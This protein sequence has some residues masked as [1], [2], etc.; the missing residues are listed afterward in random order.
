MSK[1]THE[2]FAPNVEGLPIV[3][4]L[5]ELK[6]KSCDINW[7]DAIE[8]LLCTD[9]EGRLITDGKNLPFSVGDL[10]VIN[11]NSIHGVARGKNTRYHCLIIDYEFCKQNGVDISRLQF[12]D[13]VRSETLNN[14]YLKLVDT[15]K[16]LGSASS[17]YTVLYART[18]LLE[19]L[20]ELCREHLVKQSAVEVAE[21]PRNARVKRVLGYLSSNYSRDLTLDRI[22][23][24]VLISKFHLSRE[25]KE[26]TGQ[27]IFGYLNTLRVTAAAKAIRAGQSVSEA[28]EAAGFENLSYFSRKF[29]EIMGKSPSEYRK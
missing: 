7:H 15:V 24:E 18:L 5:D 23:K 4:H 14:L 19:I 2:I 27:T 3:Y 22:A 8:L 26:A 20:L 29:K 21:T 16:G 9:G 10:A 17:F 12:D 25:F 11:S 1:V 6:D 13:V 28:A